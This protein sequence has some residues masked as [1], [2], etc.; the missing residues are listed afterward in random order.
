MNSH[1]LN[2]QFPTTQVEI[3]VSEKGFYVYPYLSIKE[4][5]L[6]I[7]RDYLMVIK[8]INIPFGILFVI[9]G[10]YTY[11]TDKFMVMVWFLLTTYGSIF[12]Y[13]LIKLCPRTL[14]F[15][16][17]KNVVFTEKGFLINKR[18]YDYQETDEI[19]KSLD[20]YEKS[21]HERLLQPSRLTEVINKKR[22]ELIKSVAS[23][24]RKTFEVIS[25]SD[26][27]GRSPDDLKSISGLG[28]V[29]LMMVLYSFSLFLFYYLGAFLG[30]FFLGLYSALLNLILWFEKPLEVEMK[31]AV[32]QIDAELNKINI[33][34]E[35]II[36]TLELFSAGE[37]SDISVVIGKKF[38]LFY[39]SLTKVVEKGKLLRTNVLNSIYSD[40]FN[41]TIFN[42][43]LKEKYNTPVENMLFV[44]SKFLDETNI[45]LTE[46]E[47]LMKNQLLPEHLGPLS[48]KRENLLYLVKTLEEQKKKYLAARISM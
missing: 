35:E 37:I 5:L 20:I 38:Q 16:H 11:N 33:Q 34:Q 41:V 12:A 1:L 10:C 24:I 31:S 42:R 26:G 2:S 40:F 19:E 47:G 28:I 48:L 8:S 44:I 22:A 21:F 17:G 46:V 39:S 4:M 32:E 27:F 18:F 30:F 3:E 25:D 36:E 7:Q 6:T 13:L 23:L 15:L 45:R 14:I 43:Y 29:L 9:V